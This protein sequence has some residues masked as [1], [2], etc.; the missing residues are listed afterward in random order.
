MD[1][2][3]ENYADDFHTPADRRHERNLKIKRALE[4][5]FWFAMA[6]IIAGVLSLL[7]YYGG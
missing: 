6:I 1:D 2:E 7:V 4:T 5:V 3:F